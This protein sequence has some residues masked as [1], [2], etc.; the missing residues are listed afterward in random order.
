M[1]IEYARKEVNDILDIKKI[2][3]NN[4]FKVKE[5]HKENDMYIFTLCIDECEKEE[6]IIKPMVFKI[7]DKKLYCLVEKN[8]L[9]LEY[10]YL[11]EN[12]KNITN[13]LEK[14]G[15][16]SEFLREKEKEFIVSIENEEG[17]Y[18]IE[19]FKKEGNIVY[20]YIK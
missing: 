11:N 3:E 8:N 14:L 18:K 19:H 7:E 10:F 12:D 1:W 5:H 13:Y 15:Y 16:N 2:L 4:G 9:I 6:E 17:L 20:K